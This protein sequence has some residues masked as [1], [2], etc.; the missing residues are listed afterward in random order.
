LAFSD[1]FR[2]RNGFLLL[3]FNSLCVD[4]DYFYSYVYMS[5]RMHISLL[6]TN[7][8]DSGHRT[9]ISVSV[10]MLSRYLSNLLRDIC[11]CV[12]DNSKSMVDLMYKKNTY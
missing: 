12:F 4:Y 3:E 9:L 5:G 7:V 2:E 11:E 8:I 6:I 10:F 1:L